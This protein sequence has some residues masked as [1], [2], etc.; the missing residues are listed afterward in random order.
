MDDRRAGPATIYDVARLADVSSATVSRVMRGTG[1]VAPS[2]RTRVLD[3]MTEL[4]FVP[5]RLGVSLAEGRHVANGIVFPSLSGPYFAE[6]VL[7]YEEAAGLGERPVILVSTKGRPAARARV[8]DLASRVDGLVVLGRTVTDEVVAEV[9]RSGLPVVTLARRPVAGTDSV[10]ADNLGSAG[11]LGR[12]LLAHGHR[13]IVRLGDAATSPDVAER[14]AGLEVAFEGADDP[15]GVDV[16][17]VAVDGYDIEAGRAEG[18]RLLAGPLPDVVV[19][20]ND[21]LAL[22]VLEAAREAGVRVPDDLAV[23]GWDD[24]MAARWAGLTT[25]RQPMR[26]LGAAAARLLE[27]RIAGTLAGPRAMNLPTEVVIRTSCGCP[28]RGGQL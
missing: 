11:A 9:V 13:R 14:W 1:P 19:A 7:G 3:A 26:E 22:G 24:V 16:T 10:T 20:G 17:D 15:A 18:R 25:V 28:D 12:H 21:E 4:A 2:T 23:T 5:S 27:A 8:L 6:V